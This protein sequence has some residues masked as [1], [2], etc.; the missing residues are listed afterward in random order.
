MSK[1]LFLV[2]GSGYIFRA[3]YAVAPLTTKSG[4]PTN[5][6]FGFIRMLSKLLNTADSEHV[7][8][9]FDA[10]KK[11]LRNDLYTEYKANRTE[12]PP[13][14]LEQMPYFREISR[15]LGL[16]VLETPGYEADDIIG[17]FVR[18]AKEASIE[19]VIV[20]GDKDLSQLVGE[21][22]TIWDTMKD[23]RYDRSAVIEKFG[24]PPEQIIDFLG[25]TG[26]SS[27][28]IPGVKGV[29]PKTAVQLITKYGCVEALF[30]KLDAIRQDKE[31]RGRE[32]LA[33]TLASS[34]EIALL[35]KQLVT[36]HS[37]TPVQLRSA[38]NDEVLLENLK[39]EDLLSATAR[40]S[41]EEGLLAELFERFEFH[42]LLKE[43]R[44]RA[45]QQ[46]T[47]NAKFT[48]IYQPDFPRW[49]EEL[50]KQNCF[51]F[52]TETT[53]LDPY[54]AQIVGV[55]FCWSEDE[56]FYL[57]VAHKESSQLQ[58]ELK[59]LL[60]VLKPL[61]E[62]PSI[63]K[64]GQNLKYDI[65]ILGVQGIET[66]G[67][68]FDTMVAAYLINPDKGGYSLSA[69]SQEY[70]AHTVI[71]YE[72]LKGIECDFSAVSV[73]DAT[74]Y[75]GEDAHCA[76]MLMKKL[77][78]I[79]VAQE[80]TKVFSEIEMPLVTV[81]SRLERAGVKLDDQFLAR[82]SEELGTEIE[83]IRSRLIGMAGCEFNLN[84]PKQLA[85]I[86]F[87]KLAIPTKGVKKTKTGFSTD[88]SVLETLALSHEFPREVLRYRM[89]HKLKSTYVDVLPTLVSSVTGRLHSRFNQTVTATGRLSSSDPNL[90]NVPIQTKEGRRI[91]QAF[92]A[93]KDKVIISA[94]YS[95]IEL[96]LLA[97]MSGD[98]NL[99]DTF[100]RNVDVHSKTAREVLHV[101]ELFDVTPEQRRIGK[102]LNFGIIYGMG[103]YRL[104]RELGI[105]M[106]EADQ[107]IENYFNRY[108]GV[109]ELF[110]KL[111]RDA[112]TQGFVSTLFGRK[113][114]ISEASSEGRDKNFQ[115]RIAVNAPIQG[116]AA[117][118]IKLAM[119][120]LDALI[121]KEKYPLI[122]TLQV[123]DELVFECTKDFAE[124]AGK[125]IVQEMEGV[126]KLSVPLKAEVG[127]GL[128][129]EVAH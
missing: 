105:P 47:L 48:T 25:L 55:S 57:P 104:S 126:S 65:S 7:V 24:I 73:E 60:K 85:E 21:G 92:I 83:E 100:I 127:V 5:A 26:D 71:E 32:K 56:A 1:K 49:I 41:P 30:D 67:V 99:I 4:F 62:D 13:E 45:P 70:L 61:L 66:E 31:I 54:I 2:D 93:E 40:R 18:R 58:I 35:S 94:D 109:K 108:P 103:P 28:N 128:N 20:S 36:I 115:N 117:D 78:P 84:S 14:L 3:F 8:V 6:L 114:F 121:R 39:N 97:H 120:K 95:Q 29:G 72:D 116:T 107:Y 86:L 52:D 113:R 96:R 102:T 122:M 75:S 15:A 59:E 16:Q 11:T 98:K 50:K 77:E 23:V 110:A 101:G 69:L 64:V 51:A 106:K 42:T 12:C 38:D 76:W 123:H 89:L 10:G 87:G 74:T 43:L 37:D 129:W 91:R 19:T 68:H 119:I 111:E 44:I 22:V 63:K 118:V 125:I 82:M 79:L 53:S 90:Q 27:D 112:A 46:K 80:L 124:E 17:T 81:L 9:V 88:S 33:E 34:K